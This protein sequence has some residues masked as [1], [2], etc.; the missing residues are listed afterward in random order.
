M[1]CSYG[2]KINISSDTCKLIQNLI[3]NACFPKNECYVRTNIFR[4][5]TRLIRLPDTVDTHSNNFRYHRKFNF[6]VY[7]ISCK[8]KNAKQYEN[9]S[10]KHVPVCYS[11]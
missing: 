1:N 6:F 9:A 11:S 4:A 7:D 8:F 3:K 10:D 2:H 5:L